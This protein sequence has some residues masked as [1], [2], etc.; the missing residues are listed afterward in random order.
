MARSVGMSNCAAWVVRAGLLALLMAA[1]PAHGSPLLRQASNWVYQL[2]GNV[3]EIAGTAAD[4][5]VIDWEHVGNRATVERLKAKPGGGRRVVL[6]YLSIGEAES[7]RS[8]YR[9]CCAGKSPAWLTGRTQ[10]WSGNYVVKFW[11]PG[12]KAIVKARLAQII[13]AGFDGVYLDRVDTWEA[14]KGQGINA[15]AEMIRLVQELSAAARSA[16]PGF[17]ILVQNGEELLPDA[18]YLAAID[19]I[20]KEDLLYGVH[21]TSARNDSG[22]IAESVRLLKRAQARGKAILVVEYLGSSDQIGRARSELK[23]LGFVPCF[24]QRSL[25]SARR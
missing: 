19:G 9:S 10:G 21:H 7:W 2:Q 3:G 4:V 16:R 12:W 20:A 8:Y 5:A 22:T 6:S 13:A 14:F 15:R 11:D 25:S 1:A 23:G 24:A 17:V 18:G